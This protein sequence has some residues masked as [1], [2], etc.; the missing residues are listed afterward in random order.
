MQRCQ[1]Q[2]TTFAIAA[3]RAAWASEMARCTPVRPRAT[4][5]RR[6]S[7]PK[8]LGLGLAD[9]EAA[10]LAPA[11]LVHTVRDHQRLVH[12]APAV[13]DLLDLRVQ[14]Q[15]RVA[16]SNGR[17]RNASNCSSKGSHTPLTSLLLR[18]ESLRQLTPGDDQAASAQWRSSLAVAISCQPVV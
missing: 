8:R 3:S 15:V 6:K 4:R 7:G 11:G 17:V 12:G 5:P 16:A 1:A 2:P 9:V 13:A 10:N 14:E 18:L